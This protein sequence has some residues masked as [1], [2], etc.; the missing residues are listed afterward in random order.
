MVWREAT[1]REALSIR[2]A[3]KETFFA[4]LRMEGFYFLMFAGLG[5]LFFAMVLGLSA[6]AYQPKPPR[7][8]SGFS[9]AL[10]GMTSEEA[11]A[12]RE[13]AALSRQEA[14]QRDL[15][16]ARQKTHGL[17]R[18]YAGYYGAFLLV[19][20]LICGARAGWFY[21][22]LRQLRSER[23]YCCDARCVGKSRHTAYRL[24]TTYYLSI[25]TPD[26]A[27]LE[28]EQVR[29]QT[30]EE[31]AIDEGLYLVRSAEGAGAIDAIYAR[32]RIEALMKRLPL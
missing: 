13:R 2:A 28:E 32:S 9:Y 5:L 4:R 21:M 10:P 15:A 7:E 17:M 1:R 27:L 20:L 19:V 3:E 26:G 30:Y 18:A 31:A 12:K 24:P 16:E 8:E 14:Y 6:G 23:L 22:L 25:R 29:P 11:A